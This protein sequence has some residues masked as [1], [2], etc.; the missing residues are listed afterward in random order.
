MKLVNKVRNID[1]I[2]N[3]IKTSDRDLKEDIK[4]NLFKIESKV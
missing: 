4:N 2:R 1:K 3:D